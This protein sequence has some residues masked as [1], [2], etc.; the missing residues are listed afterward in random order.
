MSNKSR[1]THLTNRGR[2]CRNPAAPGTDPPVCAR[3]RAA[4]TPPLPFP[5][6]GGGGKATG[7]LIN[8]DPTTPLPVGGGGGEGK[9]T[10]RLI[11]GDPTTPLPVASPLPDHTRHFYFPH[12]TADELAALDGDG[13]AADLMAEVALVRVVLRRLLALLN[14]GDD[15]PPEELRRIAGLLFTGARTV[16]A[17]LGHR[18][19]RPAEAQDWLNAALEEMAGRYPGLEI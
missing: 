19:A 5:V 7:R 1:C 12:P 17:L 18:A 8:G 6:G 15:L 11:N 14:E 13:P 4:A 16:A 3:H 10:G 9:A 2:P